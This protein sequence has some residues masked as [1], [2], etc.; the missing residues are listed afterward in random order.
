MLEQLHASLS[1]LA[2]DDM[3]ASFTSYVANVL[4]DDVSEA[5]QFNNC[6]IAEDVYS[7]I[8]NAMLAS[9]AFLSN[10]AF[11]DEMLFT[12]YK[13]HCSYNA[14]AVDQVEDLYANFTQAQL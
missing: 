13:M 9:K 12:L 11:D 10:I 3:Y 4:A 2:E 14:E 5:M 8:L 1:A 7:S 6:A